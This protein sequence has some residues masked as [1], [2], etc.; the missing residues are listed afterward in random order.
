M[1]VPHFCLA[2]FK[3]FLALFRCSFEISAGSTPDCLCNASFSSEWADCS[4]SEL[5]EETLQMILRAVTNMV[6][7]GNSVPSEAPR[8]FRW[9]AEHR[10]D[11]P[12][13]DWS[14]IPQRELI[15]RLGL[16]DQQAGTGKAQVLRKCDPP[17]LGQVAL[18][19]STHSPS[20]GSALHK[21]R[22][23]KSP[24][25]ALHLVECGF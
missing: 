11:L 6:T 8:F 14:R 1:S 4:A 10:P 19:L 23:S 25:A 16:K 2:C 15:T 20:M 13:A 9:V 22:S 5:E 7:H 21:L 18:F 17:R 12:L 3:K 24:S